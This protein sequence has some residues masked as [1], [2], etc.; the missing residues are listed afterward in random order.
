MLK[1]VEEV[2]TKRKLK[3]L[4]HGMLKKMTLQDGLECADTIIYSM[5]HLPS[6]EH[7]GLIDRCIQ[8]MNGV[9][10]K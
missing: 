3:K 7:E 4:V 8:A 6:Y 5:R 9:C 10:K 2:R 1:N